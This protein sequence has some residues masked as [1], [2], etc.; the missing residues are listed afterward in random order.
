MGRGSNRQF[1]V[2]DY[3]YRIPI[4]GCVF[5]LMKIVLNGKETET[6]AVTVEALIEELDIRPGRVAVEVNLRVIKKCDYSTSEV[7]EGD[8]VEIV[9]FV[10]GG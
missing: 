3:S 1:S 4:D 5:Y 2:R 9:N 8:Q 7:K 10:G 6:G